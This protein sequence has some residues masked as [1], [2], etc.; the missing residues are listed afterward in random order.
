MVGAAGIAV[1]PVVVVVVV[2]LVVLVVLVGRGW[3]L[4]PGD[5]LDAGRGRSAAIGGQ[6]RRSGQRRPRRGRRSDRL[7]RTCRAEQCA[8]GGGVGPGRAAVGAGGERERAGDAQGCQGRPGR[9]DERCPAGESATVR[10]DGVD[11]GGPG[12]QDGDRDPRRPA[13]TV[14]SRRRRTG[15]TAAVP[16]DELRRRITGAGVEPVPQVGDGEAGDLVGRTGRPGGGAWAHESPSVLRRTAADC[17]GGA[18]RG[19]D[20][21]KMSDLSR[22]EK[23]QDGNERVARVARRA[24]SAASRPY[25]AVSLRR[26][27]ARPGTRGLRR[28]GAPRRA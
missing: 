13:R 10:D 16:A 2:V 25:P 12:E 9:G 14:P 18:P 11:P 6:R 19:R 20:D 23:S 24:R 21:G 5:P 3:R 28:P 27:A 17:G 15:T 22:I 8:A 7:G 26:S 4:S 1:L